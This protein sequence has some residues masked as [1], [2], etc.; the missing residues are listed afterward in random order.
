MKKI[1][2]DA[3][4]VLVGAA[5]IWFTGWLFLAIAGGLSQLIA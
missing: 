5:A 3:A 2:Q 4:V 1:I